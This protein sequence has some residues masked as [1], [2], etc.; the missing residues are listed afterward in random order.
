MTRHTT[1]RD[2]A[3]FALGVFTV[4]IVAGGLLSP[5]SARAATASV[6]VDDYQ[7]TP[8]SRTITVGDVVRWSFS[9][10]PHSVTSRDRL[11]DSGITD[12][13][14]SFQFTFTKA[15]TYAYYCVVHPGLM[16]GT[17]VVK[18]AAAT[19]G[20]TV[21]PTVKPTPKPSPKPTAG[22]T[23]KPA[24]TTAPTPT[25]TATTPASAGPSPVPSVSVAPSESADASLA[26][27]AT[28]APSSIAA[29]PEPAP[30][31]PAAATDATPVAAAVA[32]LVVLVAGGL[33]L[34]RRR[35]TI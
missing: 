1:R 24:S 29:S 3:P 14:G 25:A 12:P 30:A 11:F 35:R 22:A 18:A 10:D 23:V 17:I 32:L 4:A 34:A 13:G 26:L 33:L 21:R 2:V 27:V 15:G 19:P 9:G 7:F 28:P 20:P 8:A 16:T 6:A 31:T 5:G